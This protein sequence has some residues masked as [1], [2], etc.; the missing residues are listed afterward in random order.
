MASS[1]ATDFQ[2]CLQ[3]L[4]TAE[5]GYVQCVLQSGAFLYQ[6]WP[7]RQLSLVQLSE[8]QRNAS[9]ATGYSFTCPT[10]P[11]SPSSACCTAAHNAQ[12]CQLTQQSSQMY[13]LNNCKSM[14]DQVIWSTYDC[15]SVDASDAVA[16]TIGVVAVCLIVALRICVSHPTLT[17]RWI[18][19]LWA[20]LEKNWYIW[21]NTLWSTVK[22]MVFSLALLSTL[23]VIISFTGIQKQVVH[24]PLG[25]EL[26]FVGP[27]QTR[28]T[29]L[30]N[31][32]AVGGLMLLVSLT[33]QIADVVIAIVLE[34]ERHIRE[35]LRVT[36]VKDFLLYLSWSVSY[37]FAFLPISVAI[38]LLTNL[39]GVFPTERVSLLTMFFVAFLSAM[40]SLCMAMSAFF[41]ATRPAVIGTLVIVY[42]MNFIAVLAHGTSGQTAICLLPPSCL[43]VAMNEAFADAANGIGFHRSYMLYQNPDTNAPFSTTIPMLVFDAFLFSV[44]AWYLDNVLPQKVGTRKPWHF[45]FHKSYWRPE[46]PKDVPVPHPVADV[47]D[48]K[49]KRRSEQRISIRGALNISMQGGSQA[50]SLR[51]TSRIEAVDVDLE[52]LSRS[53]RCI[54]IQG[55]TRRFRVPGMAQDRVAVDNLN[56]T[57]YEGHIT[58][59]LG[60]NGAGKSTLIGMLCGVVEPTSGDARVFGRSLRADIQRIRESLGMCPQHDIV[61]EELTTYENLRLFAMLK[62][63][64][65]AKIGAEILS[66]AGSLGLLPKLYERVST[67]SGGQKRKLC[68]AIALI[69]GSRVV[70]LDEPTAGMDPSSRRLT[71]DVLLDQRKGRVIV[72]TTHFMDESDILSDRI[73]I[74]S[75][76]ALCCVG[77]SLFLKT[78]YGK[79]YV[80]TVSSSSASSIEYVRSLVKDKVPG[81][82]PQTTM[83]ATDASF[84]LPLQHVRKFPDLFRTLEALG[85]V[86]FGISVTTLEE[87]FLTVAASRDAVPAAV[88]IAINDEPNAVNPDAPQHRR[89][90]S[91]NVSMDPERGVQ[92]ASARRPTAAD[93][94]R[95]HRRGGCLPIVLAQMVVKRWWLARRDIR[96]LLFLVVLPLSFLVVPLVI[97][98]ISITPLLRSSAGV[99][100]QPP[101]PGDQCAS[102]LDK[103]NLNAVQ[104]KGCTTFQSCTTVDQKTGNVFQTTPQKVPLVYM[105]RE[106]GCLSHGVMGFCRYIPWICHTDVCCDWTNYK[107]PWYPCQTYVMFNGVWGYGDTNA[108]WNVY[109]PKRSY[110]VVEGLVNGF[111]RSLAILMAFIFAPAVIIAHAVMETE[112]MRNTKFQQ[113]VSGVKASVYWVGAWIWDQ[114]SALICVAFASILLTKYAAP[115]NETAYGPAIWLCLAFAVCCVPFAYALS[116]RFRVSSK[117]LTVMLVINIVT[118]GG[119]GIIMYILRTVV[120]NLPGGITSTTLAYYLRFALM[121]FPSFALMDGLLVLQIQLYTVCIA[122]ASD[123]CSGRLPSPYGTVWQNIVYLVVVT[124]LSF[125]VLIRSEKRRLFA[126]EEQTPGSWRMRL[127]R[128]VCSADAPAEDAGRS[129]APV[130][131]QDVAKERERMEYALRQPTDPLEILGLCK[132]YESRTTGAS[133]VALHPL[134]LGVPAGQCFGY[135]GV[136]GAGKSTTLKC[137]T[138][139][140]PPTSGT[141]RIAGRDIVADIYGARKRAAYCPQFDALFDVLTVEQH[142]TMYCRIRGVPTKVV[143]TIIRQMQLDLFRNVPSQYLSGGNKRKLSA[144]MA[145]VGT[146]RVVFLDEPSTGMDPHTKRFLWRV[147]SGVVQASRT[148]VVLTTHS[149]EECEALC[150]RVAILIDGSLRCIGPIQHLK[151]RFGSGYTIEVRTKPV[152]VEMVNEA[153]AKIG[154]FAVVNRET[155]AQVCEGLADPALTKLASSRSQ[156]TLLGLDLGDVPIQVFIKWWLQEKLCMSVMNQVL[157][158]LKDCTLKSRH[159]HHLVFQ[160]PMQSTLL[161]DMFTF[162]ESITSCFEHYSI[163]QTTLEE[164]FNMFA[165]EQVCGDR[166]SKRS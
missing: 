97:P 148:C 33:Y 93:S 40:V 145:L 5:I 51:R 124:V 98:E 60:H 159:G 165:N 65:V 149:M 49:S 106:D 41:S 10:D 163:S 20:L 75:D 11:S 144:A 29:L 104:E 107:S 115:I 71:W 36:G 22:G 16:I 45:P 142:L 135:L 39:G 127:Y 6:G 154:A 157:K 160:V 43:V 140:L 89:R 108:N 28:T 122:D 151:S 52:Q 112:P 13:Y 87:V 156:Q 162:M 25:V 54:Q 134:W 18:R 21:K 79:G 55:L 82:S 128:F 56:L 113:L 80:L 68:V 7:I 78:L 24:L 67:L 119:L 123:S 150:S 27:D 64:H 32:R 59:L 105:S 50:N 111:I 114:S 129:V 70:F 90:R 109:C 125:V 44:L 26:E 147:I 73:A 23:L 37:L 3:Q 69:G 133:R 77:S 53:N 121:V 143:D 102:K 130:E 141:A 126:D 131:D 81:S 19:Q 161:S 62:G 57:L 95:A 74:I 158:G 116:F 118:G 47:G 120:I 46:L 72:L 132:I 17:R 58:S 99:Y 30:S 15:E 4:A 61:Y 14:M 76:G 2:G 48:R 35:A 138:G 94:Q 85:D 38:A 91:R 1:A 9:S 164:I 31:L 137:L 139:F 88:E 146:P 103:Q 12:Q 96:H 86:D 66:L 166:R 153:R 92:P 136:N 100:P 63:V 117:A 42:L 84:T 101:A 110:A 8:L 34:K 152:T 155:L 83:N